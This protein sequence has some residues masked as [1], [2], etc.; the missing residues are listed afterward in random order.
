MKRPILL[1]ILLCLAGCG[2]HHGIAPPGP[3]V[4]AATA[5]MPDT[6]ASLTARSRKPDAGEVLERYQ[7]VVSKVHDRELRYRITQRIAALQLQQANDDLTAGKKASFA[8]AIRTLQALLADPHS[9]ADRGELRY[10]LAYAYDLAGD[11]KAMLM[12]LDAAIARSPSQSIRLESRFRR[13]EF[14]FSHGDYR[15]AASDYAAVSNV[16]CPWQLHAL[17]ML[18]WSDF[19]LGRLNLALAPMIRAMRMLYEPQTHRRSRQTE[20]LSDL[21]RVT[22]ITLDYLHG[23]RTLAEVMARAGKPRWQIHLYTALAD[24][25]RQKRRFQDSART[26]ETFLAQNP[27]D[28]NAPR[29]ALAVID[30]Y[31]RA[32]FTADIDRRKRDFVTHYD[33]ASHFYAVHGDLVFPTY[34]S[35]LR[36]FIEDLAANTHAHAQQSKKAADFLTAAAWYETWQ[37]NFAG[38]PGTDKMLYLE[39]QALDSGDDLPRAIATWQTLATGYPKETLAREASYAIILDLS[40]LSRETAKPLTERRVAASVAFA[41]TWPNDPRAP[42]VQVSAAK[43]RF[44][45]NHYKSAATLADDAL[46]R[47]KLTNLWRTDMLIAAHSHFA[48]GEY[49]TAETDYRALLAKTPQDKAIKARLMASVLKQGQA[50]QAAGNLEAAIGFYNKLVRIDP[51]S[52]L[53]VNAAYDIAALYEKAGKL[54]LAAGQLE[55]FRHDH[56]ESRLTQNIAMRLAS[57]DERLSRRDAAAAELIRVHDAAPGED[58]GRAAL[59]HAGELY[60][61]ARDDRLAIASFR[62]YAHSYTR[63]L[64]LRLEAMQ[65]LDALYARRGE[66]GKRRYWLRQKIAAVDAAGPAKVAERARYLAA[67]AAFVLAGDRLDAFEAVRLRLPL[68]PAL[69]RKQR[70]MK[71][72]ISAYKRASHY[73]VAEFVTASTYEIA[74]I[75]Q[76][77]AQ[78]LLDSQRPPG[79]NRLEKA[80]YQLLLEEQADPFVDQAIDIFAANLQRGWHTAWDDWV[81]KSVAA[82]AKLSPGRYKRDE[83][84][85]GYADTLY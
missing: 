24:W 63:P 38:V 72:A 6:R 66:T 39:A 8:G 70:A 68:K 41:R 80:Q 48:L 32:G 31:R 82:L 69:H 35:K 79:M 84:E 76:S 21:T 59:Y 51:A 46:A 55:Q 23:P 56:P 3:S 44:D 22:V 49:A 30:T 17:Y 74:V 65:H 11:P 47:W 4:A 85:A 26:W 9:A 12:N 58:K 27:M 5:R 2:F 77:L 64:G 50:A 18:G 81:D 42:S 75:Y 14:M 78:S 40:A 53:S 29:I 19:K 52:Q 45:G 1:T 83:L 54:A 7:D 57:L 34:A 13:A 43:M 15:A 20:L 67:Q 62:R 37:R 25:Y 60:L 36:Q 28:D 71:D 33:K 73:G 10:K 61:A 16:S